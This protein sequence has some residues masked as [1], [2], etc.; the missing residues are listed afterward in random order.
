M[1]RVP[2]SRPNCCSDVLNV[3]LPQICKYSFF[4]NTVKTDM[5]A[6]TC[7]RSACMAKNHHGRRLFKPWLSERSTRWGWSEHVNRSLCEI[8]IKIIV[9]RTNRWSPQWPGDLSPLGDVGAF[10]SPDAVHSST[11]TAELAFRKSRMLYCYSSGPITGTQ[12]ESQSA[13]G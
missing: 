6:F 1:S 2:P 12:W 8:I 9:L 11:S 10:L 13:G 5:S 7:D 4:P 3:S